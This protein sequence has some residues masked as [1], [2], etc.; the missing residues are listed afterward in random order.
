MVRPGLLLL[1]LAA[2]V[3]KVAAVSGG[4]DSTVLVRFDVVLDEQKGTQGNFTVEVRRAGTNFLWRG[5]ERLCFHP[6]L[7]FRRK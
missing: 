4:N 5:S 2:A 3:A 7:P 1:L 6:S